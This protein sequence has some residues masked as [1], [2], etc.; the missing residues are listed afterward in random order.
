METKFWVRK[1]KHKKAKRTFKLARG[2]LLT[3]GII[4]SLLIPV[5]AQPPNIIEPQPGW[6][7]LSP[8]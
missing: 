2:L 6:V 4:L 1:E 5:M 3:A 7:Q 8:F